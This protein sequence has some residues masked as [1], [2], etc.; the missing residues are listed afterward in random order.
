MANGFQE[1]LEA[2]LRFFESQVI[3]RGAGG[4]ENPVL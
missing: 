4:A 3:E 2:N 1:K